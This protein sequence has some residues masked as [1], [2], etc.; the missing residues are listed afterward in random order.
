MKKPLTQFSIRVNVFK[1]I[2]NHNYIH[3]NS[4]YKYSYKLFMYLLLLIE[5]KG[6]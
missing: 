2:K 4:I 5:L 6:E 1:N 3:K